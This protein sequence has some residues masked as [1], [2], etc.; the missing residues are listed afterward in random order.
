M[1]RL[2]AQKKKN[3]KEKKK[4]LG[5]YHFNAK[6]FQTFLFLLLCGPI[7]AFDIFCGCFH[8]I[9]LKAKVEK[10]V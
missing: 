2:A 9:L 7:W 3:S 4:N 8:L 1:W 5:C 6:L 10:S